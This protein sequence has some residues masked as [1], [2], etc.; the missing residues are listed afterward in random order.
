MNTLNHPLNF[1]DARDIPTKD[2]FIASLRLACEWL[3]ERSMSRDETIPA[4]ENLYGYQY[5]SCRTQRDS[6]IGSGRFDS[7]KFAG[8]R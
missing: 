3:I 2:G 6:M 5:L 4:T 7:R 1:N 8:S